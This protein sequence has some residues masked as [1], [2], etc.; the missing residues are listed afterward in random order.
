MISW[1]PCQNYLAKMRE[2]LQEEPSGHQ[3]FSSGARK[4]HGPRWLSGLS[5]LIDNCFTTCWCDQQ[6][7][8]LEG[9]KT[10]SRNN[11]VQKY[12]KRLGGHLR[13]S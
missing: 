4:L 10:D 11:L 7:G 13:V 5:S 2:N 12:L 9:L 3:S 6:P 1:A 8:W